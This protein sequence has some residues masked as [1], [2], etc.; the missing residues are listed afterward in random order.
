MSSRYDKAYHRDRETDRR[1]EENTE[2][3]PTSVTRNPQRKE[4]RRYRSRS[5]ISYQTRRRSRSPMHKNSSSGTLP[6]RYRSKSPPSH[7]QD[8]P[9]ISLVD[10]KK[11]QTHNSNQK[12][13]AEEEEEEEG[14]KDEPNFNPSGKLA[15]ET[16]TFKGVVLK[17]HEPAEAR[18]PSTKQN[19]R[20]YVFKGKEQIDLFHLHKQSAFLFGRDRLVVD[21]PID[22][23]S[24]SKQ[25]AVIQFRQVSNVNEFG[26][27]KTSI[28]PF[29]ID[30][31]SANGTF[32]NG[33]KIPVSR[34]YEL[35]SGDVI[36]FGTS[37]REFVLI[38]ET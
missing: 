36:K 38:P 32:V 25:H 33:E 20:L 30:L 23:P 8:H 16:K 22:H 3:G 34:Y 9:S 37:S 11:V 19:W 2:Q 5:P 10:P 28:K 7:S 4:D 26:D 1:R 27:S 35:Q 6:H 14:E 13:K 31:E 18:K 17:Y 12:S 15:A 29:I 24:S 21:V